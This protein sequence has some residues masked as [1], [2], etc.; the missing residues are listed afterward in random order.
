MVS[1]DEALIDWLLRG[2]V[3]IQYQTFRDLLEKDKPALQKKISLEG[4]GKRFLS[5]QQNNGH[6][7]RGFYQPKWISTHYTILDLRN[8]CI[9]PNNKPIAQALQLILKNHKSMDGGINPAKTI[10][11]SDVCVSGMALNYCCYFGADEKELQSI[12]DFLLAE[13]MSDGGFNCQSNQGGA[14]HSSLH[15]TISVLEGICEYQR[16]GYRYRL[17]ELLNAE[18]AAQEFILM[19][20][21][22]KSDHTGEIINP[23][24]MRFSYPYRWHYDVLRA[25]DYFQYANVKYDER[26]DDAFELLAKKRLKTG[27]W[28][29]QAKYPGAIHFEMEKSGQ[30]SRWNTLRALRIIK[31]FNL[32]M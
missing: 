10:E 26:M 20:R 22:Y 14:R 8:L 15:S 4:W 6:W 9:E 28:P 5:K 27:K 25:L 29:L 30:A 1:L 13:H 17:N 12:V 19:H 16:R 11:A 2:D 23:A 3:S 21:L 31:H 24:F 7:G 18:K 32:N